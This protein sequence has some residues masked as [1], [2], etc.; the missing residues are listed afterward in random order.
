MV[1]ELYISKER[2]TDAIVLT[3]ARMNA[4][5]GRVGAITSTIT[6]GGP[7]GSMAD[8]GQYWNVDNARFVHDMPQ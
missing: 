8:R 7:F 6:R 3:E 5:D 2:P 1:F 4:Y